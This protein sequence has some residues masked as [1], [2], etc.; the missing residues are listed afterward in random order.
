MAV[1]HLYGITLPNVH[2][3]TG[4]AGGLVAAGLT[5]AALPRD[6]RQL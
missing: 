6:H 2:S 4:C 3:S 1:T 5:E